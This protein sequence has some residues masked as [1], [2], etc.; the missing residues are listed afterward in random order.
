MY[1]FMAGR[2]YNERFPPF[3]HHERGPCW[4]ARPFSSEISKTG[5]LVGF[6]FG[7]LLA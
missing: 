2:A 6:H 5:N 7:G 1:V 4:L 3:P